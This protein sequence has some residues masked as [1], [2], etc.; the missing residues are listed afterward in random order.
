MDID[1]IE[2]LLDQIGERFSEDKSDL[3]PCPDCGRRTICDGCQRRI[4]HQTKYGYELPPEQEL[5]F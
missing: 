5:L 1:E 3:S 2:L 4:K